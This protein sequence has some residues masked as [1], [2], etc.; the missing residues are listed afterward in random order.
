MATKEEAPPAS[1]R[2][3]IRLLAV[4][5]DGLIGVPWF[6]GLRGAADGRSAVAVAARA[7]SVCGIMW[8]A[9]IRPGSTRSQRKWKTRPCAMRPISLGSPRP[10]RH[11]RL[12]GAPV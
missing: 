12:A 10:W 5:F 8:E 7:S 4:L 2:T 3:R 11:R 1:R 9:G 6:V